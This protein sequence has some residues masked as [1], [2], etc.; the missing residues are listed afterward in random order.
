MVDSLVLRLFGERW[1]VDLSAYA[2]PAAFVDRLRTLWARSLDDSAADADVVFRPVPIDDDAASALAP[3]IA[4]RVDGSF[5]YAFSRA[6]TRAVI[7]RHA[8][9]ALLLHAA[10]LVS[11]DG[12]RGIVLVAPSGTGKSTAVLRLGPLF[13]YL[14]DELI[15]IDEQDAL[16]GLAKPISLI[17][18]GFPGSKDESGPDDLGLG[19]TPATAPRL[20]ALVCL[21]RDEDVAEPRL[22]AITVHE[23]LAD[24]VPQ[25]SSLWLIDRPLQRVAAA[26]VRHGGPFRLEYAEIAEAVPLVRGLLEAEPPSSSVPDWIGHPPSQSERWRTPSDVVHLPD[27]GDEAMVSRAPWSDAIEC[28]D[29]VSILA[30]PDFTRVAGIAATIWLA[31]SRPLSIAELHDELACVHGPHP[32]AAELVRD[33]LREMVTRGL[34]LVGGAGRAS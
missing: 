7:E 28:A 15:L 3:V 26:G 29:E 17:V 25:T 21:R 27:F 31:C 14:S 33:A 18:P 23:L 20:G 9:S 34:A 10:G 11:E 22:A 30:G 12:R 5:P 1:R 8:G 19:P 24:V 2:D 32:D 4:D 6:V 13:G 16:S